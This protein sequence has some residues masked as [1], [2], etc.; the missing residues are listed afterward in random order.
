MLYAAQNT[1]Q[2]GNDYEYDAVLQQRTYEQPSRIFIVAG[3]CLDTAMY[4]KMRYPQSSP[5][6][7]NMASARNP[8]GGWRSGMF[9]IIQ[10]VILNDTITLG[11]GAQ[12]ENLHRRTN[13]FQCLA[14]PYHQ[15][16]GKRDWNY[17]IPE[18]SFK[19]F[20]FMF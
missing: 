2:Y 8:G 5:V 6:V 19:T 1:R 10:F 15:L 11:A 7:L 13:M 18:V 16:E 14:D 9:T 17:D 4:F 3:D 20:K 12:E